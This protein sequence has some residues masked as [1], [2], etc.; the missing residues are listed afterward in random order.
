MVLGMLVAM[1]S[2]V[3]EAE[4][5]SLLPYGAMT[6]LCTRIRHEHQICDD[7][8]CHTHRHC[9]LDR[10]DPCPHEGLIFFRMKR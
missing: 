4:E 3:A 1:S 7:C 9:N 5:S 2:V 8:R 10:G 6:S